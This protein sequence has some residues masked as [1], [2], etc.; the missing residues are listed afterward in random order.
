MTE[1]FRRHELTKCHQDV[2]QVMIVLPWTVRDIGETLS[3]AHAQNKAEN[4]RVLLKILQN[5][6]LGLGIAFCGHDDAE[7][8]SCS[9]SN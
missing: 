9:S 1:G 5:V 4:R 7:S 2:V 6:I 3:S 8:N